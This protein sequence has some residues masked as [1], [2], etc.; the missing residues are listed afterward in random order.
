MATENPPFV[1]VFP[2]FSYWQR[3]ISIAMLVC[4]RVRVQVCKKKG[5][6]SVRFFTSKV[7]KPGHQICLWFNWW[8]K[9]RGVPGMF[10]GLARLLFLKSTI[11]G[12]MFCEFRGRFNCWQVIG[13]LGILLSQ[14]TRGLV[15]GFWGKTLQRKVFANA[16][17]TA[18]VPKKESL[19]G[20]DH[21][22]KMMRIPALCLRD[23]NQHPPK[24]PPKNPG[25]IYVI[26]TTWKVDGATPMY[27]FT[28]PPY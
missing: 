3:L 25:E 28:M 26:Y 21:L 16:T 7:P 11:N 8:F 6:K 1:D 19:P 9:V 22:P 23:S 4:W 2:I 17:G 12:Q 14:G 20:F 5:I 24:H 10:V 27:W 13:A 18:A 15:L